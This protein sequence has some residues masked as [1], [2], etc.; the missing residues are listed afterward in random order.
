MSRQLEITYKVSAI[1]RPEQQR[2]TVAALGLRKLHQTVR[3][4]DNP[5]IRGMIN[6]I[7]HLVTWKEI[8]EG[9]GT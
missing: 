6:R 3:Q 9:E 4:P 7:Q 1:G 2:R 5:S 8:E